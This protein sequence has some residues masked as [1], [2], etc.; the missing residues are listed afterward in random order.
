MYMIEG[1]KEG[2]GWSMLLDERAA[3]FLVAGVVRA[4]PRRGA[5]PHTDRL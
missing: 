2:G 5:D 3:S 4:S 1:A